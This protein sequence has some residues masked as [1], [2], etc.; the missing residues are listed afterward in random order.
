MV[1][2]NRGNAASREEPGREVLTVSQPTSARRG[3]DSG[4]VRGTVR[5]LPGVLIELIALTV[6]EIPGVLGF[7][8]LRR[9][10]HTF[11]RSSATGRDAL[12]FQAGGIRVGIRADQLSADVGI[13]VKGNANIMTVSQAIRRRVG[14]VAGQTLGMTVTGVNVHVNDIDGAGNEEGL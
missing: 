7:S 5:I 3:L 2:I 12:T 6:R 11:S 9:A 4:P 8:T 10:P 14:V 1:D 13:V